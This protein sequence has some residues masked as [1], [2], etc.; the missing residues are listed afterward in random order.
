MIFKNQTNGAYQ[1]FLGENDFKIIFPRALSAFIDI[2]MGNG[3]SIGSGGTQ[4]D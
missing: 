3:G 2:Y 1:P 4:R